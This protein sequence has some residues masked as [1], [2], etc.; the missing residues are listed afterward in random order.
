M[1]PAFTNKRHTP[2]LLQLHTLNSRLRMRICSTTSKSLFINNGNKEEKIVLVYRICLSTPILFHLGHFSLT[3]NKGD[4]V[5]LKHHN[6]HRLEN[7]TWFIIIIIVLHFVCSIP[8][9]F[10]FLCYFF[11]KNEDT[12]CAKRCIIVLTYYKIKDGSHIDKKKI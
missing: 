11:I 6:Y 4:S 1:K 5:V 12:Y 8:V 10:N 2:A 3:I 7:K 9:H